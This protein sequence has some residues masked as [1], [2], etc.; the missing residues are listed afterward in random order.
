[1]SDDTLGTSIYLVY[2][3]IGFQQAAGRRRQQAGA[4]SSKPAIMINVPARHHTS[5]HKVSFLFYSRVSEVTSG[6]F[7][8]FLCCVL[9]TK[10]GG[11]LLF[12]MCF[13]KGVWLFVSCFGSCLI[14]AA[15]QQLHGGSRRCN[16]KSWFWR[17]LDCSSI[18]ENIF[19]E[20]RSHVRDFFSLYFGAFLGRN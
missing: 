1:M 16:L 4:G 13:K 5:Q 10:L 17:R 20:F 18:T 2:I 6:P 8:G 15:P 19:W 11:V 12:R 3:S 14:A 7:L 9:G